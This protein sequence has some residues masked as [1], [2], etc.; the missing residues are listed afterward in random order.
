M[1]QRYANRFGEP[2]IDVVGEMYNGVKAFFEFLN[3][4]DTTD[5]TAW[6]EGFAKYRWQ[7]I[8]RTG[9]FWCGKRLYE[10]DR[11]T[12]WGFWATEWKDGKPETKWAAPV[13]YELFAGE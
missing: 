1:Y 9:S 4:Q 13:P 8:W 10:I 3:G 12:L 11:V 7:G 6:M 2:P 5:T